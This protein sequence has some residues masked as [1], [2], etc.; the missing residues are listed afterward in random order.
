MWGKEKNLQL[1]ADAGFQQVEIR[2]LSH[3][4]QNDYYIIRK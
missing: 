2:Q 3:D 1:L 4:F